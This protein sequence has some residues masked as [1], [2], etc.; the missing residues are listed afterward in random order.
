MS[1]PPSGPEG[2][3]GIILQPSVPTVFCKRRSREGKHLVQGNTV[4]WQER[5]WHLQYRLRQTHRQR[6][7]KGPNNRG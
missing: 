5:A 4:T 1:R 7:G 3:L 6:P 2:T